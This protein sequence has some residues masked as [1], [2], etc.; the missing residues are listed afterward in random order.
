LRVIRSIVATAFEPG[1][2]CTWYAYISAFHSA[3]VGISL[4]GLQ[5]VLKAAA[6]NP[7]ALVASDDEGPI[8]KAR[9][10]K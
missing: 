8:S 6:D 9:P 4:D 7:M 10:L 1:S 2:P 3:A 5:D